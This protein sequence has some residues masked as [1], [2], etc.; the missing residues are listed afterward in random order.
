M[1]K[2]QALWAMQHDWALELF[3]YADDKYA[4]LVRE[5]SLSADRTIIEC[6]LSFSDFK[7]LKAWA[8]Y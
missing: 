8:G 5:R 7:E 3:E 4:V 1:T 2:K 6:M